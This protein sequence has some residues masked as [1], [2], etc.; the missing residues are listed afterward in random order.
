MRPSS[1]AGGRLPG[2]DVAE[3]ARIIA[4]G[5]L[6]NGRA[7][8]ICVTPS[9]CHFLAESIWPIASRRRNRSHQLFT[10]F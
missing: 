3:Q 7:G 1:G 5:G 6:A 9:V 2:V 4:L 8:S 10:Q